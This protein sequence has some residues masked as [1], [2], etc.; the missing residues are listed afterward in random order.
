MIVDNSAMKV[1]SLDGIVEVRGRLSRTHWELVYLAA[2]KFAQE[3]GLSIECFDL[4]CA[5]L[6]ER[7]RD[8]DAPASATSD[9]ERKT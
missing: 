1:Q 6:D 8:L 4:Q 9:S 2:Q 5:E 3:N 7:L